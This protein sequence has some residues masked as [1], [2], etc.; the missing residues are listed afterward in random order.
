MEEDHLAEARLRNDVAGWSPKPTASRR[1]PPR[2]RPWRSG[3]Q[4]G[5]RH[6]KQSAVA[7][8][9]VPGTQRHHRRTDGR[10]IASGNA[11]DNATL[12]AVT[13]V[14]INTANKVATNYIGP[15]MRARNEHDERLPLTQPSVY[16]WCGL[17]ARYIVSWC[18]RHDHSDVLEPHLD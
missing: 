2:C 11:A 5:P 13:K 1:W 9:P 6:R 7:V 4:C 12:A 17:H 3:N 15:L 16:R 18:R 14:S 8:H 10:A